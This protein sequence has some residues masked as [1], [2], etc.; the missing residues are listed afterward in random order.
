MEDQEK[1]KQIEQV[2]ARFKNLCSEE[3]ERIEDELPM[4]SEEI[5]RI[6]DRL[7]KVVDLFEKDK[8][9]KEIDALEQIADEANAR[10]VEM[11]ENFYKQ[12]EK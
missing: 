12:G 3:I 11:I 10:A 1:Q 6:E 9:L 4:C 5:E 8:L 2:A 7:P